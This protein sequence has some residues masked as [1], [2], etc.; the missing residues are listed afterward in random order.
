MRASYLILAVLSIFGLSVVALTIF[1]NDKLNQH[2]S[3]LIAR[4]CLVEAIMCWNALMRSIDPTIPIC[5][6]RLY[7]IF[8]LT[9]SIVRTDIEP[10]DTME[11]R[12]N[13]DFTSL[14][15]LVWSNQIFV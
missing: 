6:F 12:A 11:K 10:S 2:P 5:Y 14:K 1:Y 4:I 9:T 13:A 8:S 7:K 15:W 3:P